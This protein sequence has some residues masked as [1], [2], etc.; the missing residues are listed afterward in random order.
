MPVLQRLTVSSGCQ[1]SFIPA[2]TSNKSIVKI[3]MVE[4]KT[5]ITTETLAARLSTLMV[6]EH[7]LMEGLKMEP[8]QGSK[9]FQMVN[10]I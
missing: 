4:L 10:H 2:D 9:H 5:T 1:L 7:F 3:T 8:M 6:E